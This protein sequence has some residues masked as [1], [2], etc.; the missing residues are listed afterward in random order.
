MLIR[1]SACTEG[2]LLIYAVRQIAYIIVKNQQYLD[3]IDTCGLYSDF[4]SIASG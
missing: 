2:M 4:N 1:C 3:V